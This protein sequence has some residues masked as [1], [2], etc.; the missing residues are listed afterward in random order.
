MIFLKVL[1]A[2]KSKRVH[3]F[4]ILRRG[5]KCKSQLFMQKVPFS[6]IYHSLF[7]GVLSF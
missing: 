2:L 1:E 4:L 3:Q 7:A 6:M 5:Y